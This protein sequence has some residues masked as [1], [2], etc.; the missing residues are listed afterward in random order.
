PHAVEDYLACAAVLDLADPRQHVPT[1]LLGTL[2]VAA[3]LEG[4]I[5]LRGQLAVDADHDTLRP[6][7]RTQRVDEAGVRERWR[8]DRDLLR[9]SVQ[10][11]LRVF[12]GTYSTCDT[13]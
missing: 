4:A 5:A 6:E 11:L 9:A 8:V 13:K 10:N 2:R 7:S 1:R 3:E 12:D